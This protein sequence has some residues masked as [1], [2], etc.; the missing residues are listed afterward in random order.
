MRPI[1]ASSVMRRVKQEK[2]NTMR[3]RKICELNLNMN[4]KI[5]PTRAPKIKLKRGT[6]KKIKNHII[7]RF[8]SV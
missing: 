2:E 4:L 6:A 1:K 8:E 5:P 7:S 3:Y